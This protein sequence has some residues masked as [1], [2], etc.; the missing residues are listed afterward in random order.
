[1]QDVTRSDFDDWMEWC[2]N[3]VACI[4]EFRIFQGVLPE[5]QADHWRR[6]EL[7]VCIAHVSWC[8][9]VHSRERLLRHL[10]GPWDNEG[11]RQMAIEHRGHEHMLLRQ[12]NPL[13]RVLETS[14]WERVDAVPAS[15]RARR[16]WSLALCLFQ[17]AG[18][19][20]LPADRRQ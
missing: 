5:P 20:T 11:L 18:H 16:V 7:G 6:Y 8:N 15:P 4:L 12:W 2:S 10:T 14:S 1:M 3:Q 9:T 19:P 13:Q 17:R